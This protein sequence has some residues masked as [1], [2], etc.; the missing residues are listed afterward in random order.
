MSTKL[1]D[2]ER[3]SASRYA[4]S[5]CWRNCKVPSRGGNSTACDTLRDPL[6]APPDG[7]ASSRA[8]LL[9]FGR[10]S[11]ATTADGAV[12]ALE[13]RPGSEHAVAVATSKTAEAHHATNRRLRGMA[14]LPLSDTAS[15]E[16]GRTDAA[17]V[18]PAPRKRVT[19]V[20]CMRGEL[21]QI[22][23]A[24]V[25]QFAAIAAF[26]SDAP[27]PLARCVRRHEPRPGLVAIRF[28]TES[29]FG[30]FVRRAAVSL[31]L[32]ATLS[33]SRMTNGGPLPSRLEQSCRSGSCACNPPSLTR[34]RT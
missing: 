11:V 1:A 17:P 7:G 34:W 20:Q 32:L 22:E 5:S 25:C 19:R 28:P 3:P 27:M 4:A 23:A 12:G 10:P 16:P 18:Q 29:G 26:H 8:S 13:R 33:T 21:S 30:L 6:T 24:H 14:L 15:N 31:L 2:D 9:V